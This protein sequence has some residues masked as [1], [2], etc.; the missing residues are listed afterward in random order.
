MLGRNDL[1]SCRCTVRGSDI[2]MRLTRF[3]FGCLPGPADH[4]L[5]L[6]IAQ[7]FWQLSAQFHLAVISIRLG[8]G[9]DSLADATARS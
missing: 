2:P 3:C 5:Q 6:V 1:G 9:E 4:L 7:D 8:M